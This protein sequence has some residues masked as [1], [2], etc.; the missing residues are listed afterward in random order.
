DDEALIAEFGIQ[1]G[2]E[3][4][5]DITQ[6][7]RLFNA[8][9]RWLE[10]QKLIH[11]QY[12]V[13][14]LDLSLIGLDIDDF[15][16]GNSHPVINPIMGI[17]EELRIIGTTTSINEPQDASLKF[18]EKFKT[19][20]EFQA[21]SNRSTEKVVRLEN[22]VER[23]SK[24]ISTI[25]SEVNNVETNLDDLQQIIANTDLEELPSAIEALEQSI[26]DLNDA[27]DGIPIY[28][29]V[30]HTTDG[31]MSSGDKVKL[32]GLEQYSTATETTD[33]LM[34]S[35]DKTKIN[36]ITVTNP[37]DLDDVLTRLEN[38]EGGN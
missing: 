18:G 28:D 24:V 37:I 38:L 17:D 33:G 15:Y 2:S 8:G 10:N 3:I 19:L 23:Q 11:T 36:K 27:L 30:T 4:W 35:T 1:G 29:V 16:I 12:E 34:S 31:L 25:R 13:T 6:P 26:T 20:D 22:T 14:A 9:L 7:S 21:E 5:D 32:D